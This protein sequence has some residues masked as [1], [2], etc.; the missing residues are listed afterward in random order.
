MIVGV[1]SAGGVDSSVGG[2]E[3]GVGSTG[4]IEVTKPVKVKVVVKV[5]ESLV[6]VR[7]RKS[8]LGTEM[9]DVKGT[10]A[11]ERLLVERSEVRESSLDDDDVAEEE[12]G[13]DE[14][15]A[16]LPEDV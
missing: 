6:I 13:D 11:D 2:I 9:D 4:G 1:D 15:A 12:V 7:V 5:D 8:V 16:A 3:F 10:A 14:V